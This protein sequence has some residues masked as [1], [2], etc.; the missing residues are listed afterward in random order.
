FRSHLLPKEFDF[1]LFPVHTLSFWLVF[2][3]AYIL[4]YCLN[5]L[6]YILPWY[7][8]IRSKRFNSLDYFFPAL[9]LLWIPMVILLGGGGDKTLVNMF[10]EPVV[11]MLIA[12]LT[13]ISKTFLF[14]AEKA[15]KNSFFVL[16]LL[17]LFTLVF[18]WGATPFFEMLL[19]P[20]FFAE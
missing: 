14:A 20:D 19:G 18:V 4:V 17:V 9:P 11:L 12:W 16:L 13:Y 6:A 3:W 8:A 2:I 1:F 7:L 10:F 15:A 5:S